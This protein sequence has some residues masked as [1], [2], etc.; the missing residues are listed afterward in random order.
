MWRAW[1]NQSTSTVMP[2]LIRASINHQKSLAK[3]MDCRVTRL[4]KCFAGFSVL[5]RRSPGE[6]GSPAA[7]NFAFAARRANQ[8]RQRPGASR[9]AIS[10]STLTTGSQATVR[11]PSP[12]LVQEGAA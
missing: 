11:L 10:V 5:V 12:D 7:T 2:D 4:R 9:L 3:G 6:G 1:Q 8:V